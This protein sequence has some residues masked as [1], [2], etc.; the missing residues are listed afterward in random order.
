M[1][2]NWKSVTRREPELKADL[3]VVVAAKDVRYQRQGTEMEM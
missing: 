3:F 1:V 2:E